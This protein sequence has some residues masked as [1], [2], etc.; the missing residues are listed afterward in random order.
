M[1]L[2]AAIMISSIEVMAQIHSA[3]NEAIS[4]YC[5][6]SHSNVAVLLLS[7]ALCTHQSTEPTAPTIPPSSTQL[8]YPTTSPLLPLHYHLVHQNPT[9]KLITNQ[10]LS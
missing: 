4:K 8:T 2:E 6:N 10:K 9:I 1:S 7:L 3:N 5:A